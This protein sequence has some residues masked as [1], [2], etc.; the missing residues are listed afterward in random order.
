MEIR[1]TTTKKGKAD[2]DLAARLLV[3]G[4]LRLAKKEL[5]EKNSIKNPVRDRSSPEFPALDRV[6]GNPD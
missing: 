1:I 4:A 6:S 3:K 5:N 2:I